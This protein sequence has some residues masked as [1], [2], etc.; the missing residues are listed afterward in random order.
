MA[1]QELISAQPQIH[2]IRGAD[3][4]PAR[5]LALSRDGKRLITNHS[6]GPKDAATADPSGAG[7]QYG[8]HL[9]DPSTG[10]PIGTL[11][12]HDGVVRSVALSRDG[13][14]ALTGSEDRTARSWDARKGESLGPPL[15]HQTAVRAVAL[16]EVGSTA[17]TGSEDGIAQIWD[18]ASGKPVGDPLRHQGSVLDVVFH[19]SGRELLTASEDGT[20]RIWSLV[21][22]D[23]PSSQ[24]TSGAELG[25]QPSDVAKSPDG[26]HMLIGYPDNTALVRDAN[27]KYEV[28]KP[29]LHERE[30][31]AV[32]WSR[33][34]QTLL[35]GC[36][37][38]T[39][40][41]WS[42]RSRQLI[43]KPFLAH[44][45]A[46][47]SVAFSPDGRMVLTG[48]GDRTARLWDARTGKPIGPTLDHDAIVTTVAFDPDGQT[49][50]TRTEHRV[51]RRWPRPLVPAGSDELFLLWAQLLTGTSIDASG[52]FHALD[53]ATWRQH[54]ER[55]RVLGGALD[56]AGTSSRNLASIP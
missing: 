44:R 29:L 36:T 49:L 6:N 32:D 55:L 1:T 25:D 46:V 39:V 40:R 2:R 4:R 3:R 21:I 34:D 45:G 28:G 5:I 17:A 30:V 10:D 53:A 52:S 11:L 42:A 50:L 16:S 38:G 18:V 26:R 15:H 54:R 22:D 33:D 31:L 43:T 37:D 20:S 23:R 35:T 51:V 27:T 24:L 14:I 8:A 41:V 7:P 13:Q 47:R 48:G 9:W 19:P 12:R 56:R